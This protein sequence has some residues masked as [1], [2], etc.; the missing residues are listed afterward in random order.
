MPARIKSMSASAG[1]IIAV[2]EHLVVFAIILF[3]TIG[4]WSVQ[5]VG[6]KNNLTISQHVAKSRTTQILFGIFGSAATFFATWSIFGWLLPHHQANVMSYIVFGLIMLGFLVAAVVP[7]IK[8]TVRGTVHNIA[9][10]GMCY[11][12]PVAILSALFWPLSD[13]VRI[14]SVLLLVT[15]IALLYLFAT[16]KELR[17]SMLLFQSGYLAVFFVFLLLVTYF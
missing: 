13:F 12:I 7:Y 4:A 9:A 5:R 2:M 6:R 8:G 15:S 16:K 1:A 11:L 14:A 10:W 17:R 3:V